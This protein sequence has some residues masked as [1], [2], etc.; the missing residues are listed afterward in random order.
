[1]D[2]N[3]VFLFMASISAGFTLW[4]VLFVFPLKYNRGWVVVCIAVLAI[5]GIGWIL[6]PQQIGYV[7]GVLWLIFG[8]APS[9]SQRLAIAN[10]RVGK[11]KAAVGWATVARILHPAGQIRYLADMN[12][13]RW[14]MVDGR[15]DEAKVILEQLKGHPATDFY[16]ETTLY[17]LAGDYEGLLRWLQ[18][19]YTVDEIK[20]DPN[21][22]MRYL[23]AL[24]VTGDLNGLV[25][26]FQTYRSTLEKSSA[27]LNYGLLYVFSACGLTSE[28]SQLMEGAF[29]PF[30]ADMK[31]LWVAVTQV[32]AGQVDEGKATFT[33]LLDATDKQVG[34]SARNML[35]RPAVQAE[36]VLSAESKAALSKI[37]A[38]Y[39]NDQRY[40]RT[41]PT[42]RIGRQYVTLALVVVIVI[43]Y[44]VE[45]QQGGDTD[46]E[47][48]YK[49]GAL[50]TPAVI[51]GG[52]WWRLVT[53]MFLHLG[54]LHVALNV[55]ALIVIGPAIES[56][57]GHV[58]YGLV[59]FVA[60]IGSAY[61]AV[62]FT[63]L[64]WLPPTV[65]V[66]ASGAIMGLFGASAAIYFYD[67]RRH[68]SSIALNFLRRAALIIGLQ[69]VADLTIPGTSLA[70]HLLG[71]IIGLVVTLLLS[72][73]AARKPRIATN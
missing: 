43:A 62:L 73:L 7:V 51:E 19:R 6:I 2:A 10:D 49:L 67:W 42:R 57:L 3:L 56:L 25:T 47:T 72:L 4:R 66:G 44:L 30:T 63:Q 17:W 34:V 50:W 53:V 15:F 45:I 65:Y 35:T 14:Y 21:I 28:V 29:H 37:T 27:H 58:R 8:I 36:A 32:A 12:R 70:I 23:Y 33:R 59:Y 61:A 71:A 41:R 52:Q 18:S 9:V 46:I 26:T 39:Q 68:R 20:R 1:M 5:A 69:V 54:L 24:G 64:N 60:G 16:A 48:L 40:D 22:V 38:Q 11:F 13:S 55:L 31:A